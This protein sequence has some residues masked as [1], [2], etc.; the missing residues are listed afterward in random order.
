VAAVAPS[1]FHLPSAEM[2]KAIV[3]ELS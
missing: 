3:I 2:P 1:T